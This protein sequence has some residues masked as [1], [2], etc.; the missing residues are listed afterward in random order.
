MSWFFHPFCASCAPLGRSHEVK[1]AS[2]LC[3]GQPSGCQSLLVWYNGVFTKDERNFFRRLRICAAFG[4]SAMNYRKRGCK[5]AGGEVAV[6]ITIDNAEE[7]WYI[8]LWGVRVNCIKYLFYAKK[9]KEKQPYGLFFSLR[10]FA[11]FWNRTA[12]IYWIKQIFYISRGA[13]NVRKDAPRTKQEAESGRSPRAL[14][15]LTIQAS[16][17]GEFIHKKNG[18]AHNAP[19][20]IHSRLKIMGLRVFDYFAVILTK[21]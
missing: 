2:R 12:Q 17:T 1:T 11:L 13:F 7:V 15:Q 21:V 3:R 6:A 5:R 10:T 9:K 8:T 4:S 16:S 18:S 19:S 14:K 20:R